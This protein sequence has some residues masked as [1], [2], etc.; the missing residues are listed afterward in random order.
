MDKCRRSDPNYW[1]D[2]DIFEVPCGEC[3]EGVE[4][5]KDEKKHKCGK[6]GV[7]VVNP[8]IKSDEG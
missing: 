5:F 7:E 4:F 2:G 1:Q 3:G 8:R 6:C